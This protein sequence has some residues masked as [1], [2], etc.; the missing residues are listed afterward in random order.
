M[1][2]IHIISGVK[3]SKFSNTRIIDPKYENEFIH[4]S[5]NDLSIREWSLIGCVN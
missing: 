1:M 3:I 5:Q 2:N 4:T